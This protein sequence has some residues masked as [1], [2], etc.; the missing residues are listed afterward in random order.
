MTKKKFPHIIYNVRDRK[1][2]TVLLKCI[3]FVNR[4]S[5]PGLFWYLEIS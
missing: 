1:H 4:N 2:A 3:L 5:K